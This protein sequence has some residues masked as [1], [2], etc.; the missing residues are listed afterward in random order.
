MREVFARANSLK[1]LQLQGGNFDGDFKDIFLQLKWLSWFDCPLRLEATN[2]N[3]Y[4]LVILKL[5]RSQVTE[6]WSGWDVFKVLI[7]LHVFNLLFVL[8]Y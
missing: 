8:L 1:F 7:L 6:D 4:N 3:F 5:S 2:L